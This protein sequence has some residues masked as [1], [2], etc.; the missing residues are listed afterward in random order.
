MADGVQVQGPDGKTYQFRA[1]TDKQAAISYFKKKGIGA[2]PK[3]GGGSSGSW[4]AS[5]PGE[6]GVAGLL[7]GAGAS[8]L[9][10][11]ETGVK[12]ANKALPKS[13]QIPDIPAKYTE[14]RTPSEK[15]GGAVEQVG[16]YMAGEGELRAALK[17]R[18]LPQVLQ[19]VRQ[20]PKLASIATEGLKA[21]G[22]GTA[23]A[24]AHGE[25][26]P[27]RS[28]AITGVMGSAGEY[29]GQVWSKISKE[30]MPKAAEAVN[31]HIGLARTD[32]PQW[33]RFKVGSTEAIGKA[34]LD[35]V[36]IKPTLAE[37][38]A[39]I[40]ATRDA[41]NTD[42]QRTLKAVPS[43]S[44]PIDAI[45]TNVRDDVAKEIRNQG[46]D[47]L[48][49]TA[50]L[51]A[52]VADMRKLLF[53]STATNPHVNVDT[54]L[55]I[56]KN[57]RPNF[58]TPAVNTLPNVND[59]LHTRLYESINDS[60]KSALPPDAAKT[61][62][63]NN[64]LQHKLIIARDA[65]GEKLNAVTKKPGIASTAAT[66]AKRAAIGAAVGGAMGAVGGEQRAEEG[67]GIGL[68]AGPVIGEVGY[69]GQRAASDLPAADIKAQKVISK[70]APK[71]AALSRKGSAPATRALQSIVAV[72]GGGSGAMV[73]QQ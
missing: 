66:I 57:L 40:E 31:R 60:I 67:A 37:Q 9:R 30:A 20:Y 35:H 42:T 58:K 64:A 26:H 29:G 59:M 7:S 16:E 2:T 68:L 70:I 41:I 69:H 52:Q 21:F 19:L 47:Y 27:I 53:G 44:V 8:V 46:T 22:L 62:T 72:H 33:Q 73:G 12:L 50:S 24:A 43:R 49:R 5:P 51:D 56:R 11:A 61:F 32:L 63:D 14:E 23:Q 1:G 3:A 10:G 18:S 15:I 25:D 45:L 48:G 17:A 65:A 55:S 36:G 34:V 28:G 54:A 13:A 6:T 71:L 4:D 38:H 39:A